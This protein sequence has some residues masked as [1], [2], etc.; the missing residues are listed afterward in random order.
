MAGDDLTHSTLQ[1][2]QADGESEAYWKG[3]NDYGIPGFSKPVYTPPAGHEKAYKEGW[4][5]RRLEE[6][7]Q[8][9]REWTGLP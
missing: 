1:D 5:A 8:L 7:E 3:Y 4:N 2:G 9:L 6:D